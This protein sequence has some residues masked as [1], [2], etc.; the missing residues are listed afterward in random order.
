LFVIDKSVS[1]LINYVMSPYDKGGGAYVGN[2]NNTKT[3]DFD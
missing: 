3:E 2:G 1:Q